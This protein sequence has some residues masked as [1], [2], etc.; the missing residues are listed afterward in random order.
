MTSSLPPKAYI[1]NRREIK[2]ANHPKR[3]AG[4]K[5]QVH[6]GISNFGWRDTWQSGVQRGDQRNYNLL[7][8]EEGVRMGRELVPFFVDGKG[9]TWG[10]ELG[11]WLI[12]RAHF[13][14]SS[15]SQATIYATPPPH[16]PTHTVYKNSERD[17]IQTE[18]WATGEGSEV[19]TD[20]NAR[21]A[22]LPSWGECQQAG[23]Y[24]RPPPQRADQPRRKSL[25]VMAVDR[26]A[27]VPSDKWLAPHSVKGEAPHSVSPNHTG[28][29]SYPVLSV[30]LLNM[31]R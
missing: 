28:G 16:L 7:A 17:V 20:L 29:A 15:C 4:E 25:H 24:Q 18:C 27:R 14:F 11:G 9:K 10:W 2:P 23:V 1:S 21:S 22:I 8:Q 12:V 31:K 6:R 30:C 3:G 13:P 5:N 19:K 26:E